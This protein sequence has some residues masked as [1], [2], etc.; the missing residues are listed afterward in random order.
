M[1]GYA[2]NYRL[3]AEAIVLQAV[4]DYKRFYKA[5]L[6]RPKDRVVLGELSSLRWFFRSQWFGLLSGMDGTVLMKRIE[7]EP[8]KIIKKCA[9]YGGDTM[10][11]KRRGRYARK[12]T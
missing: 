9:L 5:Y 10:E 2:E 3:L 12:Q 11:R 7:R 1:V 8:D 4:Q 6:K